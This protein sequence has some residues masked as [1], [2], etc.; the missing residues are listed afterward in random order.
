MTSSRR[1]PHSPL[2][3]GGT[4]LQYT[5]PKATSLLAKSA[6]TPGRWEAMAADRGLTVRKVDIREDDL[7]LDLEDLESKLSAATKLVAVGLASNAVGTINPVRDIIERAHEV[8]ALTY[9]DA[10]AYAPH[11][12]IDVHADPEPVPRAASPC[13]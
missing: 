13:L 8:G 9:V 1:A 3:G 4:G 2:Y 10:V 6:G 7:T 12:P 11:G 5:L